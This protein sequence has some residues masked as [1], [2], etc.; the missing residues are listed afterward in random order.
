MVACWLA[1]TKAGAVVVNTMPM[2]RAGE[3]AQDHRQGGDRAA[4]SDTR[5][6]GRAGRL[7]QG[8]PLPEAGDR[9]R[10]HGQPRRRTRPHRARQAGA[11]RGRADRP[12]RRRAARLHLRHDRR[13]EGDDALPSRP[14]DHCRRLREGGA[15]RDARTMSSSARR[16]LPSPSAS[17]GWRSSRCASAPP[18]RCSRTP[19]R[20]TWSEIIETYKATICF[21]A[22]TAYRAML[23]A[24]DRGADLS[25]L[26]VAVSAGETLPAPVFEEWVA[27]TGKPILDGIGATEMLHIFI[28]NRV[29]DLAPA[30]TGRPVAGY[31]A[32]H[33]RRRH[34]ARCRAG[35]VGR[36]AVRGPTG[37]RYLADPRQR[38]YVRDGWN[39]TGDSFVAG[40]R[41]PLPFRRALRRHDH[42]GG[43]QHRRP[44]S[45]G[46]AARARRGRGM[47]GG[48]RRPTRSADRSS[49]PMSCWRRAA[50][51]TT[52]TRKR[53]QDHVKASIAPYKYP[54]SLRF[55]DGAAEDRRPARSSASGCGRGTRDERSFCPHPRPIRAARTASSISTAT[56]LGRCPKPPSCACPRDR[57]R[58][59][60]QS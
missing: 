11:L 13:A 50:A 14:A 52:L 33:R 49:R 54:R 47:R 38:D 10:R 26:R 18:R 53:L 30:T 21:T 29:D 27:K 55:V 1:A 5:H 20:P 40:R 16:R 25:S 24:M 43:L 44:R 42:L 35:T 28:S 46:G 15:R 37:C 32:Q 19:R 59:G 48:R 31:E 45:R 58:M 22:P 12:R 34:A 6:H 8:Q 3:L 2:L 4:L 36:L 9:L 23:A 7:R 57:C 60:R 56:R 51:P 39:L 17:A 41:R